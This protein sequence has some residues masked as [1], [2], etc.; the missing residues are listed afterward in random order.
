LGKPR[1]RDHKKAGEL[2]G[3]G[4]GD[5]QRFTS[6]KKTEETGNRG[7]KGQKKDR[8]GTPGVNP[9]DIG[10]SNDRTGKTS[11]DGKGLTPWKGVLEDRRGERRGGQQ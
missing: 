8:G 5:K 10:W 1:G 7:D 11:G 6:L 2:G 4:S 3:E 9:V